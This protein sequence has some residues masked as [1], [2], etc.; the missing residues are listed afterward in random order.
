MRLVVATMVYNGVEAV[1]AVWSGLRAD[2]IALVGFGLDS[3]IELAAATALLWRL[4]VERRGGS[5]EDV[6]ETE[7]RVLRFIGLTFLVLAAY[8]T[9]E[10]GI[11]LWRRERPS[12]SAIGIALAIASLIVM[13][14]VS[15]GKMRAATALGSESLRAEAK[16]TLACSYLS[17]TLLVGLAANALAG[18]WWA[19]PVAALFMVPW[20]VSEGVEGWRGEEEAEQESPELHSD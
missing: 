5:H 7:R 3:V 9:V 15:F 8:V 18:W 14:A 19:D 20:L 1:I 4:R 2:S 11:S 16:E 10:A 17:L 6:E 12:E 13:P